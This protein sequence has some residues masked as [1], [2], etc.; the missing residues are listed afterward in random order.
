M[1]G[2]DRSDIPTLCRK[3]DAVLLEALTAGPI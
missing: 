3:V 2:R 1:E